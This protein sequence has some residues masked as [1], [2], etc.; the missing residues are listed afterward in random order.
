VRG[1]EIFYLH[2]FLEDKAI[3]RHHQPLHQVRGHNIFDLHSF[4]KD[5]AVLHHHQTLHQVSRVGLSHIY[6][7]YIRYFWQKIHQIYGHV[8]R[9]YTVLAN[10]TG[11]GSHNV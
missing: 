1:H 2:F 3:W 6:T 7:V 4:L 10:P 11:E 8:R 5:K 9:I